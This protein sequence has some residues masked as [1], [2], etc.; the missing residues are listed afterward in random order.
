MNTK[1]MTRTAILLAI[2]IVFQ[3]MKMPQ[4]VTGS[5]VN[6]M[7]LIAAG[8]VGMWSG[9]IIGCLTPIIAFLVGIMGFPLMIPFIMIGNS[10][11]VMLF[12]M[13]KNKILGMI[14]G[15]LVKFIWLAI[16]VK[17]IIQLFNVKVPLK[18]VQ[19]F[20]TPQFVTAIIG[21]ILGLIVISLLENYFRFSKE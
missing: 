10:L 8:T 3:F 18:I 15:A 20:T 11:Y 9:I 14:L 12:S 21:G 6:A 4:L 1:F 5:V 7:L 17:Y 2:T 16:S 13:Q 19:A